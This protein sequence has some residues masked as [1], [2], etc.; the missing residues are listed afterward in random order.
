MV[1]NPK[2]PKGAIFVRILSR[3]EDMKADNK[4]SASFAILLLATS[5][6]MLPMA[7]FASTSV[8]NS[9]MVLRSE[10]RTDSARSV[11]M[12]SSG[13]FVTEVALAGAENQ[14]SG[15]C[16]P[17]QAAEMPWESQVGFSPP[18][19]TPGSSEPTVVHDSDAG[20]IARAGQGVPVTQSGQ[21][22]PF[23]IGEM[24]FGPSEASFLFPQPSI[25]PPMTAAVP[26][27]WVDFFQRRSK[28]EIYVEILELMKR[29]PMTPFEVAFYGRLN[30]KRTKEYVEFLGR[31]GYLQAVTEEGKITYVLT[32]NGLAFLERFRALFAGVGF[33]EV[34]SYQYPR[35]F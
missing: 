17:M 25:S 31:R 35:D 6:V 3:A 34:P 2:I 30:R 14:M 5:G 7:T 1:H 8:H 22:G 24:G 26:K 23:R 29:G 19:G 32:K 9:A 20:P 18:P 13:V 11:I 10:L 16:T 33:I 21:T 12:T 15:R 4:L 27:L 28:F